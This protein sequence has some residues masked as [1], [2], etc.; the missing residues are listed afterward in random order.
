M[1]LITAFDKELDREQENE[2]KTED[3]REVGAGCGQ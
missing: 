2:R 3:M 1:I